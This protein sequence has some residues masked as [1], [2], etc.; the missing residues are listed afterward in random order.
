MPK[1]PDAARIDLIAE[2]LNTLTWLEFTFNRKEKTKIG[3]SFSLISLSSW[4][5]PTLAKVVK[6]LHHAGAQLHDLLE[7][8]A[9]FSR[10]VYHLVHELDFLLP[11]EAFREVDS[12]GRG[13]GSDFFGLDDAPTPAAYIGSGE[14]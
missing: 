13:T 7:L 2:W 5:P 6:E 12:H 3:L 8:R 14:T 10:Y 9:W 11:L 1:K 4:W